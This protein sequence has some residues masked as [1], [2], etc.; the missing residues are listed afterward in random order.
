MKHQ[1]KIL[2]FNSIHHANLQ[3]GIFLPLI[4]LELGHCANISKHII[5][6]EILKGS[7]YFNKKCKL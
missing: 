1:R 2:K 4:L 3:N 7:I 5:T 6:E